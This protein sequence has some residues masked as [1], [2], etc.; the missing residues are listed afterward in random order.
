LHAIPFALFIVTRYD[1]FMSKSEKKRGRPRSANPSTPA[2]RMRAYRARKR[3]AGLKRVS[4]WKPVSSE[5]MSSYS[6]HRL[7]DARSLALHCKIAHK[8][9]KDRSLLT[10]PEKNLQR[11]SQNSP[12][13]IPQYIK[14][15]RRILAQPWPEV[16]ALMT[17]CTEDAIRLR[18]SSPFAGVLEPLERKRI[19]EAFRA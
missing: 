2:E 9:N 18:Q 7:L 11:W 10:I 14:E 1:N 17:S 5:N 19:Y 4:E 12:N 8:I 3:A 6:D 13:Q 15:W 16:A